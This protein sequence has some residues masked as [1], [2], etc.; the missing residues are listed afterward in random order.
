MSEIVLADPLPPLFDEVSASRFTVRPVNSASDAE[1]Q[2][3][4]GIVSYGHDIIDGEVMDRCP[5]LRVVSN[6]GVGVDHIDVVA[7]VQRGV[8]V[9]NTPGCLDSS[10]ADMTMALMLSVARNVVVG[11]HFARSPEFTHYDPAIYVGQEVT[12]ST[13]GIVGMGRIGTEV[14]KRAKAFE[15]RVL[16]FNRNRRPEIEESVGVEFASFD[17][18]L[19]ES[20]FVSFSCPLTDETHGMIGTQQLK[21]MKSSGILINVARGAIVQTDALLE[22]LTSGEIVA[23]GLDVTDPEPLPRDHPLLQLRNVIITPHLGSAS[24]HTR[25]QMMQMTVDNLVAGVEGRKL[26]TQVS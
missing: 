26:P 13:L 1:L 15:M 19:S 4:V 18:L 14:A 11:D 2:Q 8:A 10:T 16:Y 21:Q 24:N 12:G 22:A 3:A 20:D 9:G 7:A 5:G 6:H 17:T 23:A 25:R